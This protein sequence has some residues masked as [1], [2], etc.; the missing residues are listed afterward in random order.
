MKV[1]GYMP[2]QDITED[3]HGKK[4]FLTGTITRDWLSS[5]KED[6]EVKLVC[7]GDDIGY[8]KPRQRTR[9]YIFC[10][11]QDLFIKLL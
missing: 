3:M 8:Q 1:D 9:F 5:K 2:C 10:F 7:K 4:A 11:H 6:E